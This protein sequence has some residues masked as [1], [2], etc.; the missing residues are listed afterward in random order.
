MLRLL[1]THSPEAASA[2]ARACLSSRVGP[3]LAPRRPLVSVL[4][5]YFRRP[6]KIGPLVDDLEEACVETGVACELV[7]NVDNPHEA[8]AWAAA[9]AC[10]PGFVVPVFSH[11]LHEARGYNRA[12]RMARGDIL[13][14]QLPPIN[15]RWL[16]DLAALF[17]AYPRLGVLVDFAPMA[18][19]ASAF[20]SLGG[21]E[22]GWSLR[23]DCG[24]T[25]DFEVSM[26]A[27]AAGWM[28]GA[29]TGLGGAAG[30]MVGAGTGLGGGGR[31]SAGGVRGGGSGGGGCVA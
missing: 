4:L 8:A 29:G 23:G 16:T 28:V 1:A 5:N 15:P 7:V 30:W 26:R 17:R 3:G 6:R 12:A 19:R 21:L 20:W 2:L 31:A 24:I 13:D 9:A 27:W 14:D 18:F 25:S 22:E 10:R 11:N